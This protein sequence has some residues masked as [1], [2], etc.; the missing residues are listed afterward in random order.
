MFSFGHCL[1]CDPTS[2]VG[3]PCE[4]L[5]AA[6]KLSPMKPLTSS[7]FDPLVAVLD[8]IARVELGDAAHVEAAVVCISA[9][10]GDTL[11]TRVV[12]VGPLLTCIALADIAHRRLLDTPGV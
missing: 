12:R 6:A 2:P 11:V 10:V 9:T 7:N 3:D 1:G 8:E 5:L 4:C